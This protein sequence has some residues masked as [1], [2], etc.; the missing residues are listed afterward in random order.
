[1]GD[2]FG[3]PSDSDH[4]IG[5]R[6]TKIVSVMEDPMYLCSITRLWLETRMLNKDLSDDQ[7]QAQTGVRKAKKRR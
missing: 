7:F 3:P 6:R 4:Q 1:M 2:A 5:I